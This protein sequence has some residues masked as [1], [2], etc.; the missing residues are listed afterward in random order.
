V[1]LKR[2]RV[3]LVVLLAVVLGL[4]QA[5]LS[6][7]QAGVWPVFDLPLV[8]LVVFATQHPS[9]GAIGFG[10]LAGLSQDFFTGELM[11]LNAFS[12]M[13]VAVLVM[14]CLGWT[15]VK[16]FGFSLAM[17]VLGTFVEV[18]AGNLMASLAGKGTVPLWLVSGHMLLGNVL[19][20][21]IIYL[22]VRRRGGR[23]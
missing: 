3:L 20:F 23:E 2:L 4:A 14:F 16:G 13:V 15:E 7:R 21:S 18:F 5:L 10:W 17:V 9:L 1:N 6:P 12:K 22:L 11:G 19:L 8:G